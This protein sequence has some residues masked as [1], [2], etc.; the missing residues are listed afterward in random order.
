MKNLPLGIQNLNEIIKGNYLYVDKTDL[1]PELIK[2]KQIFLSRPRRFGKSLLLDSLEQMFRGNAALFS[3]LKI[4][5]SGYEFKKYPVIRLNMTMDCDSPEILKEEL[6]D[7]LENIA[8]SY[9]NVRLRARNPGGAL[10]RL[11]EDISEECGERVVALIDEYDNPVSLHMDDIV[12]ANANSKV[13]NSFYVGFKDMDK[14]LRFV[15]VTGVTRYAMMGLSSGLNQLVDI[16]FDPKFPAICGFTPDELDQ[17]FGDRYSS[18]L[19]TLKSTGYMPPESSESDLRQEILSWYDGYTWDGKTRVLNPISILNFF[20]SNEFKEFWKETSPSVT[21]LR[22]TISANPLSFTTNYL[23]GFTGGDISLA[24]VGNVAS[25][26][27]L[28]HTGYL[29]IDK[30]TRVDKKLRY[31]FKVPNFELQDS[32]Y[33]ILN[34]CLHIKNNVVEAEALTKAVRERNSELLTDIIRT[35]FNRIPAEHYKNNENLKES[36][37]HMALLCYCSGLLEARSEEPGP[38]GDLDLLIITP[39]GL[40]TVIELK[41]ARN[42]DPFDPEKTLDKLVEKALNVI[43]KKQ[44]GARYRLPDRDIIPV[45][46]GVMG[47]GEAKAVFGDALEEPA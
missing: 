23:Q 45:G 5:D 30:I 16:S 47:R 20:N 3:G 27:L 43:K 34:D 12:L 42:P 41:Y 25:V 17:Y 40:H 13:L 22:N 39:D 31:S 26:P 19:E 2:L 32:F 9:K 4:A 14:F 33:E 44:Y 7:N 35:L 36:F 29:T 46:L 38:L 10:K 11:I 18:T 15:M 6:I 24:T 21:F 1:F 37:F 28:F 8:R